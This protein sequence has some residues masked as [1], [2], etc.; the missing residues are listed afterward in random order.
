LFKGHLFHDFGHLPFR[1]EDLATAPLLGTGQKSMVELLVVTNVAQWVR[2]TKHTTSAQ[3]TSLLSLKRPLLRK[4]RS[5][6]NNY[7][8][9]SLAKSDFFYGGVLLPV[10][11][12][13][14]FP[15]ACGANSNLGP[16]VRCNASSGRSG[17][18]NGTFSTVTDELSSPKLCCWLA[19]SQRNAPEMRATSRCQP[20]R[21]WA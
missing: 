6:E 2:R 19:P 10:H 17:V 4:G 20:L 7:L 8:A 3:A 18:C 21:A 13:L 5:G 9:F 15:L 14:A 11:F 1:Q 16:Q 12:L